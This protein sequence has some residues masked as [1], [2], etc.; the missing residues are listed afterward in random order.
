MNWG[1]CAGSNAADLYSDTGPKGLPQY[2]EHEIKKQ[3]NT[4]LFS[5]IHQLPFSFKSSS[6]SI[7]LNIKVRVVSQLSKLSL[8]F[9]SGKTQSHAKLPD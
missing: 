6:N 5:I 7:M 2:F 8:W 3:E 9:G 1:S 4:Y